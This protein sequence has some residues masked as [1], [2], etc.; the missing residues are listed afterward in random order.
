M[1]IVTG[2]DHGTIIALHQ[3]NRYQFL[4]TRR[5]P[6]SVIGWKHVICICTKF[7]GQSMCFCLCFSPSYHFKL[8]SFNCL[9]SLKL[10]LINHLS[11]LQQLLALSLFYCINIK[12]KKQVLYFQSWA[13]QFP[14]LNLW[15]CP[16]VWWYPLSITETSPS[17]HFTTIISGALTIFCHFVC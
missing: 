8:P 4:Y 12:L 16:R 11:I 2:N 14:F 6:L 17:I 1:S 3:Y 5:Y 9:T 10:L 13:L 15:F 7:A